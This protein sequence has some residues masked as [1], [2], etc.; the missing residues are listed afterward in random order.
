TAR[1]NAGDTPGPDVSQATTRPASTNGGAGRGSLGETVVLELE[2][3]VTCRMNTTFFTGNE[4][5]AVL[6]GPQ[7]IALLDRPCVAF[8]AWVR[9]PPPRSDCACSRP[10]RTRRRRSSPR[11]KPT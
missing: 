2:G 6:C 3:G 10:P 1:P 9:S 7:A 11:S 4:A 8:A 5:R